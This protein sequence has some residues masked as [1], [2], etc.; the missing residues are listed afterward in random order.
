M[1]LPSTTMFTAAMTA[2]ATTRN[3]TRPSYAV[4]FIDSPFR[5]GESLTILDDG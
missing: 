3:C 1:P 5:Q 4:G 2:T